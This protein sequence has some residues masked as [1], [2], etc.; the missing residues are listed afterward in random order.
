VT[1]SSTSSSSSV[2]L[3]VTRD[4]WRTARLSWSGAN[5]SS[6]DV[7]RNGTKVKNTSNDGS[8]WNEVPSAGTYT[9]KICAGGSTWN[10]SNTASIYLR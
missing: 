7:Y 2:T 3:T 5:W 4:S 6:V 8:T 9:Y 1:R 10:C